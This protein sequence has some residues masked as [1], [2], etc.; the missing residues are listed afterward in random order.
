MELNSEEKE[1]H[2]RCTHLE[3]VQDFTNLPLQVPLPVQIKQEKFGP[4]LG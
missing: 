4:G 3:Q 2:F 1:V